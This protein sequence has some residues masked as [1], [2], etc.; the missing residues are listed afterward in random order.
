MFSLNDSVPSVFRCE[1]RTIR[2]MCPPHRFAEVCCL[3]LTDSGMLFAIIPFNVVYKIIQHYIML[4]FSRRRH[5]GA[6]FPVTMSL[7]LRIVVVPRRARRAAHSFVGHN[8]FQLVRA[9]IAATFRDLHL[10][11]QP[12]AA[13]RE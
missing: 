4:S 2:S 3:Y 9:T 13:E 6:F 10:L 12:H 11:I 8:T 7:R 1:S 5:G